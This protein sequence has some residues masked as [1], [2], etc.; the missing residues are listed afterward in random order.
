[1]HW[2]ALPSLLAEPATGHAR[3]GSRMVGAALHAARGAAGRGRAAGGVLHRAA[4]GRACPPSGPAEAGAGGSPPSAARGAPAGPGPGEEPSC[5]DEVPMAQ[6]PTALQALALL[7]LQA[8]GLPL[9]RRLPHGLPLATL[10]ALRPHAASL[11]RMGCRTW[12][13]VRA[14][15]RDGAARRFGAEPLRALTRPG[16]TCP[17]P[18]RG[19]NC[20]STSNCRPSCPRRPRRPNSCCGPRTAC[21]VRCATGCRRATGACSRW[22]CRGAT[23]CADSTARC[24]HRATIWPCARPR[25]RRISPTC[26]A[27]WPNT[28]RAGPWRRR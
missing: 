2:I 22:S 12:G 9:P 7:R 4:L 20:R 27:C 16:A 18:C 5:P 11:E 15:P 1:M 17:I 26:A 8:E 13:A 6:A 24:F 14:L 3:S 21:W 23:T 28:L 10:T 19:W 25:R